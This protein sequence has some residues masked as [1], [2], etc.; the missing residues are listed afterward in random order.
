MFTAALFIIARTWKHS[1]CPL[2][3]ERIQKML[4]IYTIAYYSVTEKE[5]NNTIC[6]NMDE[7][8]DCHTE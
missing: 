8:R 2:I 6:S 5:Q 4:Y 1:K 3:D 7:P